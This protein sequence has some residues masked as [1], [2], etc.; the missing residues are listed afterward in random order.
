MPT[1]LTVNNLAFTYG[2]GNNKLKAILKD[3]KGKV[4]VNK[5]VV[6][7]FNGKNYNQKTNSKGVATLTIGAGPKKYTTTISFTNANYLKSKDSNCNCQ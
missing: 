7:N 6:F 1:S 2:D 4:L 5:T 3:K